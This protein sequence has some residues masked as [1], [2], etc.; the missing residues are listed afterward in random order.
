VAKMLRRHRHLIL[1][2]FRAK[3]LIS[4]GTVEG[5]NGKAKL[6]TRKAYG[7]RSKEGIAIALFHTLGHLPEPECTHRFC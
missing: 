6:T 2:W 4:S 7:F 5:L 3:G 1:N